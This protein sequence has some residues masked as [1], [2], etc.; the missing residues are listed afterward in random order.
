MDTTVR[1]SHA[2]QNAMCR[3]VLQGVPEIEGKYMDETLYDGCERYI[4]MLTH[5]GTEWEKYKSFLRSLIYDRDKQRGLQ[6][7]EWLDDKVQEYH[8]ISPVQE[9]NFERII[10]WLNDHINKTVAEQY[11]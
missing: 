11:S 5:E 7:I 2:E 3:T 4:T 6:L 10:L 1:C 9:R 8:N